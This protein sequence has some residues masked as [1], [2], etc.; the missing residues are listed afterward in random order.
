M[1]D[2]I[3]DVLHSPRQAGKTFA[4]LAL[5]DRLDDMSVAIEGLRRTFNMSA[6]TA[7]QCITSVL[8]AYRAWPRF[9]STRQIVASQRHR[10]HK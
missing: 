3:R 9:P 4:A 1:S 2:I 6:A 10:R 7:E 5:D 8:N